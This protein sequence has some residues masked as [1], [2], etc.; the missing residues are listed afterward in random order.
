MSDVADTTP[1]TQNYN[2]IIRLNSSIKFA[3]LTCR[4]PE[5]CPIAHIE[6][7]VRRSVLLGVLKYSLLHTMQLFLS[8]CG[9]S[10]SIKPSV[11]LPLHAGIRHE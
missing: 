1:T 11:P 5:S 9:A 10:V 3:I 6:T 4:Q 7:S 2:R 8:Y